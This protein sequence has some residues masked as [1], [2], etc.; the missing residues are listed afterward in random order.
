[1]YVSLLLQTVF[2]QVWYPMTVATNSRKQKEIIAQYL[3]ET[4]DDLSGLPFKL[5]DFGY[6]GVSSV[7][8]CYSVG[9]RKVLAL[10]AISAETYVMFDCRRRFFLPSF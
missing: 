1:M 6:R 3:H 4:A 5:H 9:S 2:V 7:E 8:V 10:F